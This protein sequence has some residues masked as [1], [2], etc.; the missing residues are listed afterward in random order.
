MIPPP[1]SLRLRAWKNRRRLFGLGAPAMML[2]EL[3]PFGSVAIDAGAN[4]GLYTYWIARR[5]SMVHSFEP[6]TT[7]SGYLRAARLPRV[8]V[9]YAAL[10]NRSG[11]AI[12]WI[13]QTAGEAS[14]SERVGGTP[15]EVP[16]MRLDSLHLSNVGFI[17]VDVEGHELEV[18]E[19]GERTIREQKPVL[20]VEIEQ[21]H[22]PNRPIQSIIDAIVQLGYD[23]ARFLLNGAWQPLDEFNV[24]VH[25]ISEWGDVSSDRYVS[26]FLFSSTGSGN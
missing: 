9:H 19:G 4:R 15:V 11:S 2:S 22:H 18:L 6:I 8:C 23:D 17:K 16:L 24:A 3:V 10:S 21:R 20:F 7:L 25:Q 5:A 1:L 26:N 13:P 14:L 12:L